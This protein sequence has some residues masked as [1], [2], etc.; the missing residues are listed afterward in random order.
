ME[1]VRPAVVVD[2]ARVGAHPGQRLARLGVGDPG[3]EAD[4]LERAVLQVVEQ[5]VGLRVVGD[6]QVHVAV[7]VEVGEADAHA[8]ADQLADPALD[9]DV[10][11][12][13]VAVV[14]VER[15]RQA[16]VVVRVA[17]VVHAPRAR[18]GAPSSASH[19]Q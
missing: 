17:V 13:A 9:R 18:T 4:L 11:E 7:A 16:L 19:T 8:L 15:V 5:E 6:E 12:R 14:V 1:D 3:H 10:R 2:V